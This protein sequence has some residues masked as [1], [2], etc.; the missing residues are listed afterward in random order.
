MRLNWDIRARVLTAALVPTLVLGV[1]LTLITTFSRISDL[2]DALAQRGQALARQLAASAEFGLFSGNRSVLER[3]AS[4]ALSSSDLKGVAIF[5]RDGTLL[6]SAGLQAQAQQS[7]TSTRVQLVNETTLRISEQVKH[8]R[9]LDEDPYTLTRE[10][11]TSDE[12]LGEVVV[13]L[14]RESL[15]NRKTQQILTAM[16]TLVLVLGGSVLLSFLLSR[17][18]TR[19][20]HNIAHAMTEIGLGDLSVRVPVE[21]GGTLQR[22]AEGVN[23][24]AERLTLSRVDLEHRIAAATL[25]LRERTEEAERANL[26]K[27]RFLA[28]ASHDL[29]QPMHALG[30]FIADLARKD[31][32]PEHQLL[33]D[34]IGASAEAMEN[35]LDSL[36]DISKLDA[37]VVV[38]APRA[39]PLGP[40]FQRIAN[41]Y[42]HAAGDRGLRFRVRP[43]KLW[44]SSD[45][46]LFERIVVNLVG[47]AL[48]YTPRGS[49]VVTARK[50]GEKRAD[51]GA[52]QRHRHPAGRAII[53]LPGVSC[54]WGILRAIAAR[55]WGWGWPIVPQ[56]GRSALSPAHAVVRTWPWFP[57]LASCCRLHA[58]AEA[59]L[60]GK[61]RPSETG[62]HRQDRGGCRWTTLWRRKAWPGYYAPGTVLSWPAKVWS[63]LQKH[64]EELEVKPG[65]DHQ[66]FPPTRRHQRPSTSSPVSAIAT[67]H[68]CL[69]C[70]CRATTGPDILRLGHGSRCAAAEQASPAQPKLRAALARLLSDQQT[71]S[72]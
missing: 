49:I 4:S 6:A 21:G 18:V 70:S 39:F 56:A 33:I 8:A 34:R 7:A 53:D 67:G 35:L 25:Q 37:G 32:D 44:V 65:R 46:L 16:L 72:G 12:Q 43:T 66:R 50:R 23:D 60:H 9:S 61:K 30:L 63:P 28:A 11:T 59:P 20:I 26:A 15:E 40:L 41:E 3:L 24:M 52:R 2:E 47:N 48:R 36:L 45:P 13:L 42:G 27:T 58:P 29:R 62:F 68:R 57:Y 10:G 22:L 5:D 51:R 19:P 64:L 71:G 14:S 31:H 38:A 1:L 69:R 17:S 55:G 54:S